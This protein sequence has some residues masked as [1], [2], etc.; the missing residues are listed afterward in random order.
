MTKPGVKKRRERGE[1]NM[2]DSSNKLD[3][4]KRSSSFKK[5]IGETQKKKERN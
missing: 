1:D 3:T 4:Q 2:M 5:K